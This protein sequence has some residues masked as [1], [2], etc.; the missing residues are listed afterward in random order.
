M[1]TPVNTV[2]PTIAAIPTAGQTFTLVDEGTWTNTT[3]VVST[4]YRF[5][6]YKAGN[7]IVQS[8]N[9]TSKTFTPQAGVLYMSVYVDK[10]D[11]NSNALAS[12]QVQFPN[13]RAYP[14]YSYTYYV[15]ASGAPYNTTAPAI[16]GQPYL[17]STI[18]CSQGIWSGNPT[19]YSYQWLRAGVAISGATTNSYTTS[20][21]DDAKA[22]SC[23][24]TA[25]NAIASI[26]VVSNSVVISP[27]PVPAVITPPAITGEARVKQ[28]LTV[29]T[30]T[31][32]GNPVSYTNQWLLDGEPI[33][34]ATGST[35]KLTQANVGSMVSCAVT[36]TN[37]TGSTTGN[38]DA[39]GPV[40]EAFPEEGTILNEYCDNLTRMQSVA[41]GNGGSTEVVKEYYSPECGYLGPPVNLT[42]PSLTG[43]MTTGNTI[44]VIPGTWSRAADFSYQWY[45][46]GKAIPQATENKLTLSGAEIGKM[47]KAKVMARDTHEG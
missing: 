8:Q 19:S 37:I 47:I 24:V 34:G 12:A 31:W 15:E 28:I 7:V 6:T 40:L 30:G 23:R 4:K 3:D 39:V 26:S 46:N 14:G 32:S 20:A 27:P 10:L 42:R 11:K 22:V 44:E 38:S 33:S 5:N 41:D 9:S 43:E 25:V 36:A 21:A 45:S 13:A 2:R 35:F 1:V 17:G 16:T 29:N 18:T